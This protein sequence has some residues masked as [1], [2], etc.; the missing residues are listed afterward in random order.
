MS[1][2]L[3][4]QGLAGFSRFKGLVC[5]QGSGFSFGSY[6]LGFQGSGFLFGAGRLW[7]SALYGVLI[8][9]NVHPL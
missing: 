7:C 9:S 3:C 8:G 5:G 1:I 6:G 4:K 2:R